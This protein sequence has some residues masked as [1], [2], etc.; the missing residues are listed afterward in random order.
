MLAAIREICA[1][2][3]SFTAISAAMSIIVQTQADATVLE[4]NNTGEV[5]V[6]ETQTRQN[7]KVSVET[8]DDS[9]EIRNLTRD[10]ALKYSGAVGVR[11]AGLDALTFV[12]VFEALIQRESAFDPEAL[13]EKGAQG[14]G[15]LMPDTASDMGVDDPFDPKSNLI[16][17]AKY[18]TN[19][20]A[21]FGSLKLALAA[22]NAGPERVRKYNDIPPFKETR[23]YI[24]WIYK[25]AGLKEDL[26]DAL[27][28]ALP[29]SSSVNKEKP[30]SGDQSVWE[31]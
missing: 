5:T 29:A 13:S 18:L 24:S 20:L 1:Y 27:T 14:L 2:R 7:A 11:K 3:V 22:Y 10:V 28:T 21:D 8:N 16:G 6:T 4:Y 23:E 15:Q 9:S 17:A 12:E 30:L 25:K 19:Q 26:P 31:F